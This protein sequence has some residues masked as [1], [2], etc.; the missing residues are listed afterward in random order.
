MKILKQ[1][2]L[3]IKYNKLNFLKTNI[4]FDILLL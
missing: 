4:S 3:L 2:I 1:N